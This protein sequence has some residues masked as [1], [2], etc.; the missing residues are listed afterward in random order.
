MPTELHRSRYGTFDVDADEY[1]VTSPHTPLPWV[2]VICPG[3]YGAVL[4]ATGD[5][6]SWYEHAGYNLVTRWLQDFARQ[7]YGR[8]IYL[9]EGQDVWSATWSP[10]RHAGPGWS[11]AHG[12]GYT[13]FTQRHGDISSV[14][15]VTVDPETQVEVWGLELE[16]HGDRPRRLLVMPFLEWCLGQGGPHHRQIHECFLQVGLEKGIAFAK[17][18][19]WDVPGT[20]GR[21]NEDYPWLAFFAGN[22]PPAGW[23]PSKRRFLGPDGDIRRPQPAFLPPEG[24]VVAGSNDA[25]LALQF[26]VDLP[27]GER[28]ELTFMLGL[29]EDPDR[30]Q[31]LK[32]R[33]LGRG[34][35]ADVRQRVRAFWQGR[36]AGFEAETPDPSLDLLVNRWLKY[37]VFSS[38]IFG[39]CGYSIQGGGYGYRE[40]QDLLTVIPLEPAL[41]RERL[42]LYARHQYEDLRVPHHFDRLT[43]E[44]GEAR[45]SDDVLWLPFVA[46]HYLKETG[47]FSLL[48]ERIPYLDD[49]RED[50]FFLHCAR[51][52]ERVL[53][54]LGRT[55]LPHILA[56]DW[57]DGLSAV[58]LAGKGE[59]VWLGHFLLG[60]L[61]EWAE[62]AIGWDAPKR[63]RDY[64]AARKRLKAVLNGKAWDG[65]WYRRAR[66]DDGRWIGGRRNR[67]GRI[68]LNAQVWAI[69]HAVVPDKRRLKKVLR[70]MEE[71]L[72]TDEGPVLL[73]PPYRRPDATVGYLTRYNPGVREN[74]GVYTH[75]ACWALQ[76]EA[77]LGRRE[78]VWWLYEQLS[79]ILRSWRNPDRTMAEPYVTSGNI[80]VP[81]SPTPGK[82]GWTWYSSSAAW[83]YKVLTEWLLGIR[84]RLEGLEVRPVVPAAWEQFV[85]RRTFR[86]CDLTIRVRQEARERR[87]LT[88]DG[89]PLEERYVPA[90]SLRK[91]RH[92]V[93]VRL[94]LPVE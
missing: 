9:Q 69:L 11:A 26:P 15:L 22:E 16:N 85:V 46:A 87:E 5:G 64:T 86:G 38:R 13:R 79:P 40:V 30:L 71:H 81:P 78:Q 84:P 55:G 1:V 76:A 31:E 72:Y 17:R 54:R 18:G 45:W 60:V 7:D 88:L 50:P 73:A 41:A 21:W 61:R 67:E 10:C 63:A 51:G 62:L 57:N 6:F 20:A 34:G 35:L 70:A 92:E 49:S 24:G 23:Q 33:L 65:Q 75:A 3:S 25:A 19:M 53:S 37:Q 56:G 14:W 68:F 52:I 8:F 36:L 4:S 43:G 39:R 66:L 93:E 89:V 94:P 29:T 48:D 82:G 47:D 77:L 83:L 32:V 44:V 42:V 12:L 59:S 2:N 90:G 74:G 27:P 58:G 80:E 91:K 28:R